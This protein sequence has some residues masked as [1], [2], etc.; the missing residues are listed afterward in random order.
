MLV[1]DAVLEELLEPVRIAVLSCTE[2][3]VTA[4]F[5]ILDAVLTVVVVVHILIHIA[6]DTPVPRG[7]H[8]VRDHALTIVHFLE[9]SHLILRV[10]DIVLAVR[11]YLTVGQLRLIGEAIDPLIGAARLDGDNPPE[12][13]LTI[14]SGS[15]SIG[16]DAEALDVLLRKPWK[17][18]SDDALRIGRVQVSDIE[19]LVLLVD[20]TIDDPQ[21]IIGTLNGSSL[22][23]RS[24]GGGLLLLCLSGRESNLHRL[25]CR[26]LLYSLLACQ[27]KDQNGLL[28][29]TK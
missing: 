25:G 13:A 16:D 4:C 11:R 26:Q 9:D 14:E 8:P 19:I 15:R 28:I 21:R 12:G 1:L 29:Y 7:S 10:E 23:H 20:D 24:D 6:V 2:V 18:S 17:R 3:I 27:R 22:T 5:C